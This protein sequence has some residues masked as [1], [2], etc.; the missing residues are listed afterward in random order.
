MAVVFLTG[1]AGFIGS[2][3]ARELLQQGH[4]VVILDTFTTYVSPLDSNYQGSL[5]ERFRLLRDKVTIQRGDAAHPMAIRRAI[6]KYAPERIIHLAAV[7]VADMTALHSEEALSSILQSTINILEVIRDVGFVKR[8]VYISSSMIYGDFQYLPAD[9]E[10]PKNPKDVYG[11]AK[12]AGE[13]LTQ[14]FG[15]RFGIEYAIVRPSAV[16]GPTDVNRRVS[17]IFVQNALQGKPL[18]LHGG[19]TQLDFTYV[20]DA[21]H[22]IVL[23]TFHP[24]AANG[25][26]NMT[27][28]EGRSLR[29]L[30]EI[31]RRWVPSV[32]IIE[33]APDRIRPKRGALDIR[34][35][36]RLLGYD[37]QYSLE[38]G[39]AEYV[40]FARETQFPERELL[41][42][43]QTA[44]IQRHPGG[45]L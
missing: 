28:G 19:D 24:A 35:A 3:V 43:K 16:Y 26:F 38:D 32:E 11:G 14:A 40:A 22:G 6:E 17:Q 7:P 37:P 42:E 8:F 33:K 21:A 30:A 44:G 10:H 5:A 18:V 34:K 20:K 12:L 25:V 9:E 4:E 23:A 39:L 45:S 2:F 27:R 15:R 1:G 29:E 13:I 41:T 36:R 31:L